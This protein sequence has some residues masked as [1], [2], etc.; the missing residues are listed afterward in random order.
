MPQYKLFYFPGKGA[1]EPI[2][3]LFALKSI[4]YEDVRLAGD[5]W[6]KNK[7]DMPFN[8]MPVLEEDGKKL[9]GSKV[10]LR[11]LA[12]KSEIGLAGSNP[13]ENAC[14]A[15]LSDFINDMAVVMY[16][17]HFE[18]DPQRKQEGDEKFLKES[19]PKTLGKLNE[20]VT[21]G[22]GYLSFERVTWPDLQLYQTLE[23]LGI[24]YP[25]VLE[26]Y[27]ALFKLNKERIENEPNISK[28]I[29]ERPHTEL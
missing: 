8:V 9:G 19:V 17:T 12:E 5:S 13:W 11:Y 16:R 23:H 3:L 21:K 24:F 14:L 28:W 22:N 29:K 7:S 15:N 25:V 4:Q 20:M 2:R 6:A 10:I 1:A 26:D 18:K 27:P